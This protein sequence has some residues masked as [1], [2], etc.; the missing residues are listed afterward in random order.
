[1]SSTI[2]KENAVLDKLPATAL[3]FPLT[4]LNRY[5]YIKLDDRV[6]IVDPPYATVVGEISSKI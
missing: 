1:M 3:Q 4:S 6:L 5:K 2:S